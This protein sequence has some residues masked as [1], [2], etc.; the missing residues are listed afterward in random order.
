MG[1]ILIKKKII[2]SGINFFEGGPLTILKENLK[3]ANDYLSFNYEIIALVHRVDLFYSLELNKIQL[4]EFPKSR[5]SY[6]IRLYFEYFYFK[7]L[8]KIWKP[9][10][11]FSLHDITPNVCAELRVVYC[12]N[13]TPFK[14]ISITDL[15][16]QPTIFYFSLFYKLLYR[17]NIRKNDFVVV[18]QVWLKKE[19]ISLFGLRNKSVLV[20]YPEYKIQEESSGK[21]DKS[22]KLNSNI[23]TFFY[24][25]LPRPFKNFEVIVE[26]IKVLEEKGINNFKVFFT[27]SGNE[28]NYSKYIFKKNKCTKNL[29]FLGMLSFD[30]VNKYYRES[31]ALLFPSTLETWGLPITEFKSFSKPIILSRLPYAF[32]TLGQYDKALFFDPKNSI[33][34]ADKMLSLINGTAIFDKTKRIEEEVLIGWGNLYNKILAE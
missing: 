32:E 31:D 33:E 25:A 26:A 23:Y 19:F 22:F 17:F 13:P 12:H 21:D 5:D 2:V 10:L 30:E 27:I 34:L 11:W 24:P 18:Q 1:E 4:I 28:N 9:Y 7:K 29:V 3:F 20:C 14:S 6:F 8:S 16:F 15:F